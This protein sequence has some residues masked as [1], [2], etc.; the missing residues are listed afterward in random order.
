MNMQEYVKNRQQFPMD[1]L[2]KYRGAYVAWSPDGKR[3]VA[4]SENLEGLD[5]LVR[6]AGED[7]T[8][9][10]VEGIPDTDSVIGGE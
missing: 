4:S 6:A 1:E 7:P 9:C 10:I 3:V 5:S 2:V 8:E